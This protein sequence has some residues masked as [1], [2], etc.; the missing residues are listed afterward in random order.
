MNETTT[1]GPILT[2]DGIPLKVSL[3][4]SERRNKIRAFLLVTPLLFF[5][6]FTFLIPIG[7]ML[8]RSVDDSY[9]NTVFPKTFEKYKKWDRQG[10]PSEELYET[11][12]FEVKEGSGFSIGKATTRMNYAK[13]GWKSLLKKSKRKFKKIEEGPYKEQMIAIDK[14]WAD[15]EYWKAI[16]VMVDPTT[17]GYFLNAVDLKYDVNKEVIQQP[18]NRRIYNATWFKTFKVSV[19]VMFFCLILGYP[20]SYLLSTLPLK[21]SNLLMICVL[22]PFWTSLLVRT[23]AWMVMLQQKGVFNNLLVMS[24]I[25]SDENRFALMYNETA[26]IIVMTQILLPFMVLPLYSVMK[27]ISPNYMRAALNLGASP[28]HAFYKVYMPN[29]IPGVSA[30]CMLVFILAIGYYITPELVGG[31]DGQ[32]IGNWIAYHLKTTLNWGLCAALGAIL[33]GVLTVLYWVYNKLVGIENIKLG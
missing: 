22:L 20:I 23:V 12:F 32:M 6:L 9:I 2:T 18:E 3:Q 26:T 11:I 28:L 14:R 30:G 5:I 15:I 13:S 1:T 29:S 24:H 33:L 8:L 19:L 16:G 31:K 17:A 21:Y 10:L 4:K 27:T 25:I 7:D